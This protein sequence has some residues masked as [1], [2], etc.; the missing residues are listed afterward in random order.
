MTTSGVG[1][2]TGTTSPVGNDDAAYS[3]IVTGLSYVPTADQTFALTVSYE[4]SENNGV[5][6][7]HQSM[8]V[9][10]Q[11]FPKPTD[12][13]FTIA[14]ASWNKTIQQLEY[15]LNITATAT[16]AVRVDGWN[17]YTK[18][19]SADDSAYALQDNILRS[20]GLTQSLAVSYDDYSIIDVRIVATRS[21]YLESTNT[22]A[23]T[24]TNTDDALD[25]GIQ[26]TQI[27]ILPTVLPQPTASDITVGDIVY[28]GNAGGSQQLTLSVDHHANASHVKINVNGSFYLI[29][30]PN[31]TTVSISKPSTP[32]AKPFTVQYGYT[33]Y[34]TG[35]STTVYSDPVPVTYTTGY[36]N[37]STPVIVS[38]AYVDA[39]TFTVTYTSTDSSYTSADMVLTSNVDI[40]VGDNDPVNVGA[41]AGSVNLSDF[42][43]DEVIMS[44]RDSFAYN[45]Y[46][47]GQ[48][49][50]GTQVVQSGSVTFYVAANPAI[51]Q[52]SIAVSAA[53][54]TVTFPVNHN[55]DPHFNIVLIVITQDSSIAVNDSGTYALALFSAPS[56]FGVGTT[57]ANTISGGAAH[58]LTVSS[59]TGTDYNTVTSF[60]FQS[61]SDLTTADANVVLYVANTTEGGDSFATNVTPTVPPPPS[62]IPTIVIKNSGGLTFAFASP[63]GFNVG[64]TIVYSGAT[65]DLEPLNGTFTIISLNAT[66]FTVTPSGLPPNSTVVSFDPTG[67]VTLAT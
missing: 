58:T 1:T 40:V 33:S 13:G 26:T 45:Y 59:I 57:Y 62:F 20:A 64:D 6:T 60:T 2:V 63:H 10:M 37:P 19:A 36:S 42:K 53:Y 22:E 5:T 66:Q 3:G 29:P 65:G 9:Q 39:S 52:S 21:V 55:G 17:V 18:L 54:N 51:V 44:I 14:S 16:S 50:Q 8:N 12:K 28:N 34:V 46:V 23:Q 31:P 56:G 24:E 25:A 47:D 38:K 61:A 49:V 43:S 27:T 11:G 30:N 15:E 48:A 7:A 67:S 41:T 35:I 4:Y 32:T